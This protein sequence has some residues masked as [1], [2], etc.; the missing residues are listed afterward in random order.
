[1]I[2]TIHTPPDQERN[3]EKYLHGNLPG[4]PE[5]KDYIFLSNSDYAQFHNRLKDKRPVVL[6]CL[7]DKCISSYKGCLD[8]FIFKHV[9]CPD[10]IVDCK[11][12]LCI[13]YE[14]DILS[15]ADFISK[16]YFDIMVKNCT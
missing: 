5:A 6:P 15:K 14:D 11:E 12:E 2:F 13:N 8:Y 10:S 7:G 1:M 9:H 16:K 3:S 4:G